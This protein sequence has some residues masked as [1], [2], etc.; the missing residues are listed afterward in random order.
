MIVSKKL[1]GGGADKLLPFALKKLYYMAATWTGAYQSRVIRTSE[2]FMVLLEVHSREVGAVTIW[3]EA[4]GYEFFTT[5]PQIHV[6]ESE[7]TD[8]LGMLRG[9][10]VRDEATKK[11]RPLGSTLENDQSAPKR[12]VYEPSANAMNELFSRRNIWQVQGNPQHTFFPATPLRADGTETPNTAPT[13]VD[14]DLLLVNSWAAS[15]PLAG[16]TIRAGQPDN[17]QALFD[18][19]Y[20]QPPAFFTGLL[21]APAGEFG[22]APDADWYKRAATLTVKSPSYA[23]RRFI[24]LSD[25]SNVFHVYPVSGYELTDIELNG[26]SMYADQAIKT[27]V[28]EKYVQRVTAPLPAWVRA[29]TSTARDFGYEP[30]NS[31]FEEFLMAV[32]QYRWAFNSSATRACAVVFEDM[33]PCTTNI[34][35]STP[36]AET[37]SGTV[38]NLTESLPGMVEINLSITL[39]GPN[40]EDFSFAVTLRQ[41]NRASVSGD[42]IMA[43]DYSWRIKDPS[44]AN[45]SG[46]AK[47]YITLLDDLILMKGELYYGSSD[48]TL[49]SAE[50]ASGISRIVI[51]NSTQ[52][53]T[54]KT[55]LATSSTFPYTSPGLTAPLPIGSDQYNARTSI[56]AYDL[57]ILAFVLQQDLC[58]QDITWGATATDYSINS[59][60]RT[61][62]LETWAYNKLEDEKYLD[63][64]SPHNNLLDEVHSNTSVVGMYLFPAGEIGNVRWSGGT[65]KFYFR[66]PLR[67]SLYWGNEDF[68]DYGGSFS[69]GAYLYSWRLATSLTL[70]HHTAFTVHPDGHWSVFTHPVFYYG[71]AAGAK[72]NKDLEIDLSSMKQGYIDIIR[73]QDGARHTHLTAFNRAFDK[74]L[75][76]ADFS[77]VFSVETYEFVEQT[78]DNIADTYRYVDT[79]IKAQGPHTSG[80]AFFLVHG[81]MH[82]TDGDRK[83]TDESRLVADMDARFPYAQLFSGKRS[84]DHLFGSFDRDSLGR[85]IYGAIYADSF[86]LGRNRLAFSQ[87][88]VRGSSLFY[89]K[90]KGSNVEANEGQ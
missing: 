67:R 17:V 11:P 75:S 87:P 55:I 47:K 83:V 10:A 18:V 13:G 76:V 1:L 8:T 15:T 28:P 57:R 41:E 4:F 50:P 35:L 25:A 36:K 62:K 48:Q 29:K 82:R 27:N 73:Y 37:L 65:S 32:P 3:G 79:Y 72:S 14:H 45:D 78:T 20:D 26:S 68:V 61:T 22:L 88:V 7:G 53:K 49:P 12:W 64:L 86:G 77:F 2:G 69:V 33:P 43:A 58:V 40:P 59:Q 56:L 5:G 21:P 24:I 89:G 16:M 66:L 51:H 6:D 60:R 81:I 44:N 54:L 63:P 23:S 42:Y 30:D 90:K 19:Y 84:V 70:H 85:R 74:S 80:F 9:Y 31:N 34:A 71:G 52:N 38:F 46:S 39:N